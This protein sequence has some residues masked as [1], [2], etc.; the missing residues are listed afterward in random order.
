MIVNG[1]LTILRHFVQNLQALHQR[2]ASLPWFFGSVL[3]WAP[4]ELWFFIRSPHWSSKKPQ[5]PLETDEVNMGHRIFSTILLLIDEW[6]CWPINFQPTAGLFPGSR[7]L[8]HD[9]DKPPAMGLSCPTWIT[10]V[11][12]NSKVHHSAMFSP[13]FGSILPPQAIIS[14]LSD[15]LLTVCMTRNDYHVSLVVQYI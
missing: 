4:F 1:D 11:H 5:E 15:S 9:F 10:V 8:A 12:D 7:C 14:S 3:V 13:N 2:P 6:R